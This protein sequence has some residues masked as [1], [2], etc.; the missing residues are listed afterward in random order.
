MQK[1]GGLA[2]GRWVMASSRR[3]VVAG[4]MPA[5]SIM[6]VLLSA[7]LAVSASDRAQARPALVAAT[8]N[9]GRSATQLALPLTRIAIFGQDERGPVPED[10][11]PAQEMIGLLYN[12]KAQI[13]CT[14]FCVAPDIVA[15]AAHC[16]FRTAEDKPPAL[17]DFVF[18][19][20]QTQTKGVSKIAGHASRSI[21]QNI[22]SGNMQ[23]RVRPPID[24]ANDWAL[25]R[26]ATPACDKGVLPVKILSN[27]EIAQAAEAKRI[28]Q[29]SYHRDY[30]NWELAYSKPCEA[31]QAFGDVS[32]AMIA[33][34]FTNPQALILHRCDT[35]GASSGSPLLL[36]DAGGPFVIGINVGTYV[37]S[38]TLVR[39]N[40]A[41]QRL[42]QDVIANTAVN[43]AVFQPLIMAL[44]EAQL[45]EGPGQ[46][47][48]LQQ[49]LSD[50]HHYSGPID[51][52]YGT[53]LRAA[54]QDFQV[55][56]GLAVTGLASQ[57][58]LGL[59]EK[60]SVA[61]PIA[62]LLPPANAAPA[63]VPLVA[64]PPVGPGSNASGAT[65]AAPLTP[66]T[67]RAGPRG[68][69]RENGGS[70]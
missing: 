38:R 64:Q 35:G 21:S 46:L 53:L 67:Q 43:A 2:S 59:L 52:A 19:R 37:L 50:L 9:T 56:Q 20:S 58:L 13:V 47:R 24:A 12:G 26:L 55:T 42:R 28:F 14:G 23:I 54:I 33:R 40:G 3:S 15:T 25:I 22:L 6:A 45:L 63:A 18:A 1:V 70:P 39:D 69:G 44:R 51:G 66:A 27:A 62:P 17:A 48:R 49:M 41:A 8:A 5:M 31:G 60:A 65:P 61:R 11:R 57:E 32:P 30:D 16:L 10:L 29:L 4:G 34:D 36:S 68:A 7:V